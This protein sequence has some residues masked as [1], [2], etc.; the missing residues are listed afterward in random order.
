MF[1][2]LVP[3]TPGDAVRHRKIHILCIARDDHGSNGF[4]AEEDLR[5]TVPA[6]SCAHI[7]ARFPANWP[8]IREPVVGIAHN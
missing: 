5:H 2:L 7:L 3:S 6:E 1:L 8:N 4:C